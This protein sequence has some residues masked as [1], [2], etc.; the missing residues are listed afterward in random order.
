VTLRDRLAGYQVTRVPDPVPVRL[1]WLLPGLSDPE[2]GG[3]GAG[4]LEGVGDT[5]AVLR[6]YRITRVP[7]PA[8]S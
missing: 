8:A 7:V 4:P 2:E 1:G 3:D 5:L 6:A